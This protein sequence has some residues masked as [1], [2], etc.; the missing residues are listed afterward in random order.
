MHR[1]SYELWVGPIPDGLVIRHKCDNRPCLNPEHLETG[2][3]A[4]NTRDMYERG[5]QRHLV[6]EGVA[7]SKLTEQDVLS[8]RA[9]YA[10]GVL[11]QQMLAESYGVTQSIISSAVL[12]K[13]WKHLE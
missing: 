3:R 6:G 5:R 11:T 2:T 7:S 4:D 8:I 9:E 12:R 1:L 13:T 10:K